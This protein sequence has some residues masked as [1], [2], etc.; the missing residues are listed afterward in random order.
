MCNEEIIKHMEEDITFRDLLGRIQQS[1]NWIVREYYVKEIFNAIEKCIKAELV[2]HEDV[3][4]HFLHKKISY[5][6][7]RN[8]H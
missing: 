8:R 2:A 4:N 5:N 7:C 3:C 1:Y 6:S